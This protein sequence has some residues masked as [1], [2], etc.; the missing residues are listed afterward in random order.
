MMRRYQRRKLNLELDLNQTPP[1][2]EP[3]APNS[4]SSQLRLTWRPLM[5]M[6]L[7]PHPGLLLRL[8]PMRG[9]IGGGL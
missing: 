4:C 3:S 9:G 2:E 8:R 1:A 7:N 5:M 6:L